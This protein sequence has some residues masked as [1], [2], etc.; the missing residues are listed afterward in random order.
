MITVMS[1]QIEHIIERATSQ[2]AKN[3]V[4]SG[5]HRRE[6]LSV[7]TEETVMRMCCRRVCGQSFI[8]HKAHR[9]EEQKERITLYYDGSCSSLI[10]CWPTTVAVTFATSPNPNEA[11]SSLRSCALTVGWTAD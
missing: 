7:D 4:V 1:D 6:H 10:G 2:T 11:F 3:V 9:M 8:L 5:G